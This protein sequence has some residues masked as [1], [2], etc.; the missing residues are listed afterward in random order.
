MLSV[1]YYNV[2]DNQVPLQC[3]PQNQIS[4]RDLLLFGQMSLLLIPPIDEIRTRSA[5]RH[6]SKFAQILVISVTIEICK[7][8]LTRDPL[9][10]TR[11]WIAVKRANNIKQILFLIGVSKGP[12]CLT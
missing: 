1:H 10:T 11:S 4:Q 2:M 5:S 6:V 9:C 7:L 8:L 3:A 12:Y